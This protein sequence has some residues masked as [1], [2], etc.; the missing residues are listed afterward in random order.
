VYR[1]LRDGKTGWA[2]IAK[3][4]RRDTALIER[5]VYEEIL[6][7]LPFPSLR[8][9]G[10]VEEPNGESCWLFLEDV[11]G[12][13]KYHPDSEQH[14]VAAARWLGIMNTVASDLAPAARLP[15]RG[16]QHYLDLLQSSRA[17]IESSFANPALKAQDLAVLET[18]LTA[19]EYLRVHW[20]RLR[21]VCKGVP[22][23]LV[24]GDLIGHNVRVR[25]GR[26]GI[27]LLPFDWEK[28][29][30]GVPAEDISRIHI[31]TYWSV[32]R[33]RWPKL[34]VQSLKRL[35]DVGKLF[36]CI[37]FLDWIAPSLTQESVAR[38]I[39]ELRRC[40]TW[41]KDLIRETEWQDWSGLM[42]KTLAGPP[43]L[44]TLTRSLNA[45][46]NNNDHKSTGDGVTVVA[47]DLN[48]LSSTYPSEV[49]TCHLADGAELRV[50]CKYEAGR[51]H[52][53]HGHRGGLPYEA[54]VYRQVL[55]R[56]PVSTASFYGL[57]RDATTGERWLF[58]EY[59]DKS[60]RIK[61][62]RD[63]TLIHAAARWLG[64]FHRANQSL[65]SPASMPFLHQHDA[66]YYLGWADRTSSLAGHLHQEFR[67]LAPLCQRFEKI[68]DTLLE[69]P[70]LIIHG[71]YY[72]GNIL[73]RDG[74]IYPVD[75]ESTAVAI[76]EIDLASLVEHWPEEIANECKGEYSEARW[77]EGPP[78]DFERKLQAGEMY[79]KLRWLGE[80][81]DWTHKKK[82]KKALKRFARLKALGERFGLI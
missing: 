50:L 40:E 69:L 43:D 65:L 57:H 60:V 79:W 4:C 58:L 32:I 29:G 3:Q 34:T 37:V 23:T 24:H 80:E 21:S 5:T 59:L 14:R 70:F 52:D 16:A 77:P 41:L 27:V 61:D 30:W 74:M 47:R 19:C 46:F 62:S 64:E 22:N 45:S 33:E 25:N 12:H 18:I 44:Q 63:R 81:V 9:Y 28:A 26:H 48:P 31:P 11:S 17:T 66:D 38:P 67:W 10:S 75:W 15:D 82:A 49:V 51:T 6:P 8:Y 56:L 68:F 53:A 35:A 42:R 55:Q 13:E 39:N 54:E 76:A 7:N 20:S 72:T 36:R 78:A 71:E 1:L 73:S 2:V